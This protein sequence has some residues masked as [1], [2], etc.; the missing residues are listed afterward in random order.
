MRKF[1]LAG[2]I[3]SIAF[4]ASAQPEAQKAFNDGVL[5]LKAKQ[6]EEAEAKFA[7]AIDK[8]TVPAGRKMA[9]IYR[10]M[11]QNSLQQF[12]AAIASYSKAIEIDSSDAAS[13]TDRGLSY[14]YK[15]DYANA[16]NDFFKVLAID[17][18]GKQAEAAFFYLGKIKCLQK[19]YSASI[20]F[21]N[22]LLQ[23]VPTD[24]EAYFL[25]GVS[26]GGL[27]N[28]KLA[29]ADYTEAI[30][31]RSNYVEAYANRGVEKINIIPAELK[32][33]KGKIC[34]KDACADLNKAKLLGDTTIDDM[35][36][37]YCNDCK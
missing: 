31:Y 3:L 6:Y 37:L 11:A 18:T 34:F 35:L 25:R 30:K 26:N 9:Y 14:S 16:C 24:A 28:S 36:F 19:D 33:A 32:I 2:F 23:L 1:F 8:G 5:L 7:I 21:L 15:D 17:S 4:S 27:L 22:K 13:Y 20:S 10:G 29:I 12:D